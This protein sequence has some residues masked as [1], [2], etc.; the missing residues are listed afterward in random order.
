MSVEVITT[1]ASLRERLAPERRAGR[2]IGFVPTMGAL[3][4]GHLSLVD[5]ARSLA[6]VVVMSIF[7]NPLQ[8][9]PTEDLARYPRPF[10]RDCE[11]AGIR[12]VDIIFAPPT[13]VMYPDGVE[14][15]TLVTPGPLARQWEGAV[16]PGHFAGVLT[17]VAKLFNIVQPDVAV[18]GQKDIQQATVLRRM[19][20]DLDFPVRLHVAPTVREPDGLALSSRNAYLSDTERRDA[21]ALSHTLAAVR[22]AWASGTTAADALSRLAA[23]VLAENPGV[24]VDYI[25]IVEPSGLE[26]VATAVEGTVVAIA[27]RVG[28]TRL[29]D[30]IIL[31]REEPECV[32]A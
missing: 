10:D 16:R 24:I 29:I 17:V 25:A 3:H 2:S 20:R 13:E 22:A 1:I 21:L 7:V 14:G 5:V 6:D 31:E 27:A 23:G 32:G 11:L 26:P 12:G 30:N 9:A 28:R 18:F 8:F 19:V 15:E 4:E